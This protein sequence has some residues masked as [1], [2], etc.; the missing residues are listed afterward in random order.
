MKKPKAKRCRYTTYLAGPMQ[1]IK[2]SGTGWRVFLA[3]QLRRYNIEV[4][5]PVKTESAKVGFKAA[6]AKAMLKRLAVL[7]IHGGDKEAEKKFRKLLR[8][9]VKWDFRMIDRSDFIIAQVIE[10]VVSVGTTA[11]IIYAACNRIPV[12]VVY[13]GRTEYFS[14]WLLHYI[15]K[16]GGK[17]FRERKRQGF[18]ECLNYLKNKFELA[19]LERNGHLP[20]RNNSHEG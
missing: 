3:K 9:I 12:Y 16:S 19:E 20:Q 15:L 6:R 14:H 4:Q 13:S 18:H 17:V 7:V 1:A 8:I 2:Y 5:D 11:E 10:G